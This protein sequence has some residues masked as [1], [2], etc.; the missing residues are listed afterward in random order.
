MDLGLSNYSRRHTTEA[1]QYFDCLPRC[2]TWCYTQLKPASNI[3]VGLSL[4]AAT[5][6]LNR[7]RIPLLTGR[8]LV[9]ADVQLRM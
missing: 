8:L 5:V 3:L 6:S 1:S 7:Q 4:A 9:G 2:A